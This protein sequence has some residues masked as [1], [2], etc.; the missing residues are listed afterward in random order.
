[1]RILS[2]TTL[3][4]F[5]QK[6]GYQDAEGPLETWYHEAK[7]DQWKSWTDIKAKYASASVL[8]GG[9]V[10]FNIGG[11]KYSLVVQI[12]YTAQIVFMRFI[13][14]HKEYDQIDVEV[15]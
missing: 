12:N 15:I 14:T 6:P 13:G 4:D 2:R 5:Y 10:V 3:K 7:R 8:K 9:R 11:N 1:V